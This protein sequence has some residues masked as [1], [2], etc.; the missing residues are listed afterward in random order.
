METQ[1]ATLE[2]LAEQNRERKDQQHAISPRGSN[3]SLTPEFRQQQEVQQ[4]Q[5]PTK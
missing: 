2:K 4:N 1:T 3:K 5:A